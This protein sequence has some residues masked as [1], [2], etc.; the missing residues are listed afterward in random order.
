MKNRNSFILLLFPA[1][2]CLGIFMIPFV[3]DYAN[4]LATEAAASQTGRWFWGH[5]VSSVAFGI[6]IVAA[7][8]IAL[9]LNSVGQGRSGTI[10]LVLITLGGIL[11]AAGLGA[12]GI[13]AVAFIAGGS[14]A[15]AFFEGSGMM[16]T[17]LFMAGIILFGFGLINQIAGLAEAGLIPG[18]FRLVL[19]GFAIVL[20]GASAI[21][22]T[23]GL[24]LLAFAAIIIY[25]CLGVSFGRC[26]RVNP[27]D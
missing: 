4:D 11:L 22:S 20:M 19:T 17:G 27:K 7:Y 18:S 6:S 23:L 21:P 24:Y 13:G 9:Y 1:V 3:S 5:I 12:D 2:L 26:Q 16:V 15:S 25:I 8:F 14:Q 10:S